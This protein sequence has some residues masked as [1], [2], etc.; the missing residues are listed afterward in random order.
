MLSA[1]LHGFFLLTPGFSAWPDQDQ[2][3]EAPST[4]NQLREGYADVRDM[5]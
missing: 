2:E 1:G 4:V 3:Q 5:L